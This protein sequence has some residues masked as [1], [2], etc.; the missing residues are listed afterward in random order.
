M[1]LSSICVYCGASDGVSQEYVE[2]ARQTGEKIALNGSR[3]VYGGG[4]LGLMGVTARAVLE[5]GGQ[6]CGIIPA[7]LRDREVQM[8]ECTELHVVDGMHPRK[9]RMFRESDAFVALPGGIG[10]LDEVVEIMTWHYL[11]LH[12]KPLVLLNHDGYWEPFVQLLDHMTEEGFLRP[13][14]RE[15]FRLADTPEQVIPTMEQMIR[16]FTPQT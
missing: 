5:H 12:R 1:S 6:V 2:L 3:M 10:T 15:S 14:V 9:E 4:A 16:D 13:V 7:H 8:Q 11:E